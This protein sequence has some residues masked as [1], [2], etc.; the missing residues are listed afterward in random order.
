VISAFDPAAVRTILQRGIA[1]GWWTPEDLD[2]PSPGFCKNR[3]LDR[4]HFPHGYHGIEH[5][6]LLRDAPSLPN[7]HGEASS[8]PSKAPESPSPV[9]HTP[10]PS[11]WPF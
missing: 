3:T 2:I 11:D 7:P 1:H 4:R 6:N 9:P 5:R 8:S 10:S